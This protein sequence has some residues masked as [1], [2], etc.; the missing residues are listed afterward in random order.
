MHGKGT[1][2][3]RY[4]VQAIHQ[5]CVGRGPP[6][7]VVIL[8][9]RTVGRAVVRTVGCVGGL[10]CAGVG[11]AVVGVGVAVA[12]VGCGVVLLAGKLSG[13]IFFML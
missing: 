12:G 2:K 3:S 1:I 8:V 6:P 11:L 4:F 5:A 9:G 7:L 10:V 13:G